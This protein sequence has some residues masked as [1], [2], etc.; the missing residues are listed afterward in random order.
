MPRLRP[1]DGARRKA[2]VEAPE[3]SEALARGLAVITAFD[4]A[5]PR[6]SLSAVAA[7]IDLPRATA[8]RAL[9]TLQHLGYAESDG[10]LFALTPHVLRLAAAF[11]SAGNAA[12]LQR[13]CERLTRE[14]GEACSAAVRDGADIVMIAH[15]SPQRFLGAAPGVGFRL[16]AFCTALGRVLLG[17]LDDAALDTF[18][19]ALQP[20]ALTPRT[21]TDRAKLRRFIVD[22]RR[23]GFAL[24]DQEAEIG[25]RSIAVPVKRYDGATIAA[26]NIG[27]RVERASLDQMRAFLPLLREAASIAL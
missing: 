7:R 13:A 11:L 27:V 19:G 4:A 16:P 17:A 8:R 18:L 3:F 26:L 6:L 25:F 14:L 21:V 24:A 2:R 22:A 9:L 1:S 15:A 20:A 12:I 10:R 5:H 23:H